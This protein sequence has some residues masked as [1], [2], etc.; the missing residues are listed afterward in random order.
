MLSYKKKP[1]GGHVPNPTQTRLIENVMEALK[2]QNFT[3]LNNN[4]KTRRQ[5]QREAKKQA[6]P[7]IEAAALKLKEDSLSKVDG[8]V[9]SSITVA[10]APKV[11]VSVP[12]ATNQIPSTISVPDQVALKEEQSK[13]VV[14]ENVPANN[15]PKPRELNDIFSNAIRY[16]SNWVAQIPDSDK[17]Q[18][19]LTEL[20]V[21]NVVNKLQN[22]TPHIISHNIR[23]FLLHQLFID[24]LKN[25]ELYPRKM[26]IVD[27]Y[28][29]Y[30]TVQAFAKA[31]PD[32]INCV[33][34]Y[35]YRPIVVASDTALQYPFE[36]SYLITNTQELPERID[37][38][39]VND[40]S[41]VDPIMSG[42]FDSEDLN[43]C[44]LYNFMR[45]YNVLKC[46]RT[47]HC[48]IGPAGLLAEGY[49]VRRDQ[50]YESTYDSRTFYKDSALTIDEI[51]NHSTFGFPNSLAWYVKKQ[52]ASHCLII[53][54]L[55]S[56]ETLDSP[57]LV[58]TQDIFEDSSV[59]N[60][61]VNSPQWFNY[62]TPILP[63]RKFYVSNRILLASKEYLSGKNVSESGGV[64][65]NA[66]LT[67]LSKYVNDYNLL[68]LQV[69]FENLIV[70][71]AALA[72]AR[73]Q[74]S[75]IASSNWLQF[76]YSELFNQVPYWT[77]LLSSI[78]KWSFDFIVRHVPLVF[79]K[80]NN[81]LF[82]ICLCYLFMTNHGRVILRSFWPTVVVPPVVSSNA[83]VINPVHITPLLPNQFSVV[84][85]RF[86]MNPI[87]YIVRDKID[88]YELAVGGLST[89]S[90]FYDTSSLNPYLQ[91]IAFFIISIIA[92][93]HSRV[94]KMYTFD[95]E[96][97]NMVNEIV[98]VPIEE[99]IIK[100]NSILGIGFAFFE[101]WYRVQCCGDNWQARILPCLV[102]LISMYNWP[103]TEG[104]WSRVR[105]HA[106]YNTFCHLNE[107]MYRLSHKA[108][109]NEFF[110]NQRELQP[111]VLPVS[112]I[113]VQP[114]VYKENNCV[115]MD[116][117]YNVNNLTLCPY[118][119]LKNNLPNMPCPPNRNWT[120]IT[121]VLTTMGVP[122]NSFINMYAVNRTRLMTAAPLS[123]V[124]QY[125]A[126]IQG[127]IYELVLL[128]VSL[129][130]PL[131]YDSTSFEHEFNRFI[132]HFSG[133][134]RRMYLATYERLKNNNYHISKYKLTHCSCKVKFDEL[135]VKRDSATIS[136]PMPFK[137][138]II[139]AVDV[140]IQVM[141]GPFLNEVA[142]YLKHD[143]FSLDSNIFNYNNLKCKW[144][145]APGQTIDSISQWFNSAIENCHL[146]NIAAA[147]DDS[148]I[149]TRLNGNIVFIEGDASAFDSTQSRGP[150][151][152]ELIL[153]AALGMPTDLINL[154]AQSFSSK[155]ITRP[156][157]KLLRC[158]KLELDRH[159]RPMRNTGG[160][161]TTFGNTML[162][163]IA[164]TFVYAQTFDCVKAAA[165][166]ATLGFTMKIHSTIEP[167]LCS[168]LKGWFLKTSSGAYEWCPLPSRII[169]MG[170]AL[171][172]P[173]NIYKDSPKNSAVLFSHDV[174]YALNSL[175]V[176]PIL[177]TYCNQFI[178]KGCKQIQILPIEWFYYIV[179]TVN[180]KVI[181]KQNAKIA[182]C[183]R[184]DC[185]EKSY[186]EFLSYLKTIRIFCVL[187]HPLFCR[188]AERD[189]S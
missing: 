17:I 126:W 149:I 175:S 54:Q 72:I 49:Y 121:P 11:D 64:M 104:Y 7:K 154:L 142:E 84:G 119:K 32:I 4:R 114:F 99:E 57:S 15:D 155:L 48:L 170:K 35:N 37:F 162:N 10:E 9:T 181:D 130:E 106:I 122:N 176:D 173:S 120:A 61:K 112:D 94:R 77:S 110:Q 159:A 125:S 28:G 29:S 111:I 56:N 60:T 95:L 27:L 137:P 128:V 177:E 73:H 1:R 133:S 8:S 42:P 79:R 115:S 97:C 139:Q 76:N 80:L 129:F 161:D 75:I 52:I 69:E 87:Q 168:F 59:L 5:Q 182:F 158:F 156:S 18:A 140:S 53:Y 131:V 71:S 20:G 2:Q 188:M 113:S 178:I 23:E 141:C 127:P 185:D 83:H 45:Y 47:Q 66:L 26:V 98:F 88:L 148:L 105:L 12:I 107:I 58:L 92:R 136:Q 150:L 100:C 153:L 44:F 102:H 183:A 70:D 103:G 41:L 40:C 184:Y 89:M 90:S 78:S 82:I 165:I 38:L 117:N 51:V 147:G 124:D 101:F 163:L 174:A 39:L 123:A 68:I 81:N 16:H 146:F 33:T 31:D 6:L 180:K 93:S 186:L 62:F 22:H 67:H 91:E 34:W 30:K 43:G 143:L 169:K 14:P 116:S 19:K 21:P 96:D 108:S 138:R 24:L 134:K 160:P 74:N 63:N 109:I 187:S 167:S 25:L 145:Y 172:I 166:F 3:L 135:L 65:R 179:P 151:D 164:N 50:Y 144:F 36:G 86:I 46:F 157:S 55:N 152:V 132:S 118:L 85:E 13:T 171:N 189:Y